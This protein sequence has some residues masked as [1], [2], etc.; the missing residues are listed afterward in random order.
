MS[1]LLCLGFTVN[2]F[3]KD[4]V[5]RLY[6]NKT[7]LYEFE[8]LQKKTLEN[9]I[10]GSFYNDHYY[11]FV[12]NTSSKFEDIVS[13]KKINFFRS[14]LSLYYFEFNPSI[15]KG[16]DC[17]LQIEIK[18]NDSNFTNGFLTKSTLIS[19]P[20]AYMI[21]KKHIIDY[22]NF[23]RDYLFYKNNFKKTHNN[24]YEIK[25]F[26]KIK[27]EYFNFLQYNGKKITWTNT[28]T[29]YTQD[30]F[31]HNIYV[32]GDGKFNLLFDSKFLLKD[33][34]FFKN[35]ELDTNLLFAIANKY[36]QYE[37]Q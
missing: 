17:Q 36:I 14:D 26:Y 2:K 16:V 7:F 4:P 3:K 27:K 11:K 25:S 32:G 34:N 21:P 19:L 30:I 23:I 1:Y 35:Y 10:Y 37:N 29:M 13:Y 12:K 9:N 20:I 15:I 33:D 18:N 31:T 5:V 28:K 24:I 22:K 6:I 8:L